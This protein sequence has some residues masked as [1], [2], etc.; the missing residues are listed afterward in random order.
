MPDADG[1]ALVAAAVRSAILAKAPRRTVAAVAAAVACALVRGPTK[2]ATPRPDAGARARAPQDAGPEVAADDAPALLAALRS[3]RCSQRR[4]KRERR[5]AG[6]EAAG[7]ATSGTEVTAPAGGDLGGDCLTPAPISGEA[8]CL[9]VA[10]TPRRSPSPRP[11][12]DLRSEPPCKV[13]RGEDDEAGSVRT[14]SIITLWTI[15]EA[16]RAAAVL[17]NPCIDH[18]GAP[19]ASPLDAGGGRAPKARGRRGAGGRGSPSGPK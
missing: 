12:D 9:A 1:A 19:G 11:L 16:D 17:T 8:P 7:P 10:V 6:K 5:R 2:A 15:P 18:H 13:A 14:S 3:A 4:R